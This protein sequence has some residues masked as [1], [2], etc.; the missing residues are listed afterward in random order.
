AT[1]PDENM[2]SANARAAIGQGR[3]RAAGA[4]WQLRLI[5]A[6]AMLDA[7]G[8]AGID[9]LPAEMEVRLAGMTERP[10][11]NLLVEIEQARL[12]RHLRAGFGRHQPARRRGGDGLLHIARPLPQEAARPHGN[13]ARLWRPRRLRDLRLIVLRGGL[14]GSGIGWG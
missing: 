10:F 9:L 3:R 8:E 11:A 12:V 6:A 7:I 4:A 13:D 14:S 1:S 2:S 5:G